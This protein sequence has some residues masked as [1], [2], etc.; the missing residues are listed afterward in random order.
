MLVVDDD[1]QA[2]GY[3]RSI[4]EDAGY[5]PVV[6]GDPEAMPG[7][8]ETRNPDL[9]LLD[10][11][12]PG[13]DGIELLQGIPALADRPAVEHARRIYHPGP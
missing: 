13:T 11:L 10:L 1:P 12:L 4:L 9:V 3:V 7:L 2:L 8:I 5:L 6:T